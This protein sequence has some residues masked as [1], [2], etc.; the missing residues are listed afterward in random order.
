MNTHHKCWIY[1]NRIEFMEFYENLINYH[2]FPLKN[3]LFKPKSVSMKIWNS[4]HIKILCCRRLDI[5]KEPIIYYLPFLRYIC[6]SN[7]IHDGFSHFKI[8]I[9]YRYKMKFIK[10]CLPETF[11][12]LL[13][14]R[15]KLN[16]H[17]KTLPFLFKKKLENN[18]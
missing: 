1:G 12:K 7:K 6:S 15:C 8:Y 18:T 11:K 10:K 9:Y 14:L 5:I 3:K 2:K 16:P 17:S 13:N 4:K